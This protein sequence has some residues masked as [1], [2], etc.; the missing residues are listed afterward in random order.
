MYPIYLQ[1]ENA[2]MDAD[3]SST[4]AVLCIKSKN[5]NRI[6]KNYDLAYR[7]FEAA[8]EK[9][10]DIIKNSCPIYIHLKFE[11]SNGCRQEFNYL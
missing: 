3:K 9:S 1:K 5:A 4:F 11:Y 10:H 2:L 8:F 7:K 6:R